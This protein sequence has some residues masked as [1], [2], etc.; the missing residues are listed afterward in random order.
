MKKIILLSTVF[1]LFFASLKAQPFNIKWGPEY[2]KDG[3]MF[4]FLK[5]GGFTNSAYYVLTQGTRNTKIAVYDF[6]HNLIGEQDI[7]YKYGKSDVTVDDVIKTP[8]GNYF[9]LKGIDKKEDKGLIGYA[10][11]EKNNLISTNV[12]KI[13]EYPYNFKQPFG[14]FGFTFNTNFDSDAEGT[15][16]SEDSS[17]VMITYSQG[18]QDAKSVNQKFSFMVM[19]AKMQKLFTVNKTLAYTDTKLDIIDYS[20]LNNGDVYALAKHYANDKD[21]KTPNFKFMVFKFSKDGTMKEA[22][23][24][25]NN[26]AALNGSVVA[27]DGGKIIVAGTYTNITNNKNMRANGTYCV[28]LNADGT[29]GVSNTFDFTQE[30]QDELFG[31][32]ERRKDKGAPAIKLK[33]VVMD[34]VAKTAVFFWEEDY[35]VVVQT[36]KSSYVRYYSNEIIASKFNEDGKQ[37]FSTLIDKEFSF[38]NTSVYNSFMYAHKN[39]YHYLIFNDFKSRAERKEIDADGKILTDMVKMDDNGKIVSRQ[40]LFGN[41]DIE[42]YAAPRMSVQVSDGSILL[43]TTKGKKY[44]YGTLILP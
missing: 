31:N 24:K 33:K 20:I 19:D 4:S 39:G 43:Q 6:N 3:G 21:R 42:Y 36:S 13:I 41:K 17:K 25:L 44:Q 9:L 22:Q 28:S 34:D 27:F 14:L 8:A 37:E 23:I 38:T 16:M 11:P 10:L 29:P 30:V 18:L 12:T 32:S 2:K 7:E 40:T 26:A 1:C 35:Y 5:F 15:F